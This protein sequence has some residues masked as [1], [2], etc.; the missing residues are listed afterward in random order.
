MVVVGLDA[1]RAVAALDEVAPLAGAP[2][3]ARKRARELDLRPAG[4][5]ERI[6]AALDRAG[7]PA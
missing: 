2:A 7:V 1:T 3:A 5:A 6:A 4:A